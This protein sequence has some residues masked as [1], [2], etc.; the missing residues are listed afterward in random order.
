MSNPLAAAASP[1]LPP[2]L[3]TPA[4]LEEQ[5]RQQQAAARYYGLGFKK[6]MLPPG[7]HR[8]LMQHLRENSD[9]FRAETPI[10]YIVNL[11]PGTIPALYFEDKAFNAA[12]SREL[13][14][15]HEAWSGMRLGESACY[16]IRVYQRGTFL[17]NHVDHTETHII[18][19]TICVDHRLSRPWP[20][21]I[22]DIN[23]NGYRVDLDPGEMLF[24]EGA[25][26]KHGRAYPL[27]GDYYASIFVH[28]RPIASCGASSTR[29]TSP[30]IPV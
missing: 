9:R 25:R 17:Y 3:E 28:Y 7:I 30:V 23:G 29:T 2:T 8:R 14:P 5:T 1:A 13:Q 19:S 15:A 16:G 12:L 26:L 24:Y 18:S 22:E 6:A 10:E 11:D 27:Q 20:L 4:H 21:Y